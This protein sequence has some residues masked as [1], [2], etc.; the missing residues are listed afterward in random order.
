MPGHQS[1]NNEPEVAV[2]IAGTSSTDVTLHLEVW[3]AWTDV[4]QV[5]FTVSRDTLA[6]HRQLLA[7][8]ARITGGTD[9]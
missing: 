8:L 5:Y 7:Q 6:L 3:T 9:V 4:V 1:T 2:A